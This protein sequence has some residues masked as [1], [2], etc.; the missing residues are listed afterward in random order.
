MAKTT[1]QLCQIVSHGG[2]LIINGS[3]MTTDQLAQIASH[4]RENTNIIV[5]NVS[6]KTTD[7]LC[8]IASHGKGCV[9]FDLS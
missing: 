7:Q 9:I 3:S 1:D 5:K 6:A 2:G 4:G 8:Q